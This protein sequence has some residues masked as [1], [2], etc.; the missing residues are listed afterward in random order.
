MMV[1]MSLSVV[2][3]L[4]RRNVEAKKQGRFVTLNFSDW[5]GYTRKMLRS[6]D[7]MSHTPW[8]LHQKVPSNCTFDTINHTKEGVGTRQ[9]GLALPHCE[10][11]VNLYS[12]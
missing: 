3:I 11:G 9:A 4:L 2:A 5:S 12:S 10:A 1:T 8:F 6:Y 7:L